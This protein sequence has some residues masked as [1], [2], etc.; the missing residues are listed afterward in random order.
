MSNTLNCIG[1]KTRLRRLEMV[2]RLRQLPLSKVIRPWRYTNR[3]LNTQLY[4]LQEFYESR[5]VEDVW[6]FLKSYPALIR[7][8]QD[9]R[10]YLL[11]HFGGN[12]TYTL[13]LVCD[14]ER[15]NFRQ[16]QVYIGTSMAIDNA[17]AQ[18]DKLDEEW[19]LSQ[20]NSVGSLINFNLELISKDGMTNEF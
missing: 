16:L 8:L 17:L 15:G 7:F 18:L 3:A 4:K 6:H 2:E 14:P 1:E 11:E 20:L 12:T 10:H 13:E 5:G 19:F 9:S